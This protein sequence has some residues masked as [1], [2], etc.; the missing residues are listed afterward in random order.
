MGARRSRAEACT[1]EARTSV[2]SS[3]AARSRSDDP[4][5]IPWSLALTVVRQDRSG[6]RLISDVGSGLGGFLGFA[7]TFFPA[8]R[9][10]WVG[11]SETMRESAS[12]NLAEFEPRVRYLPGDFS[13][14]EA[15]APLGQVDLATPARATRHLLLRDLNRVLR[16]VLRAARARWLAREP[17]HHAVDARLGAPTS[18]CR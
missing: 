11:P 3:S 18:R 2:V 7:L 4:A 8:T 15:A 14:I 1:E 13:Q 16:V 17:R 9:G 10:I 6:A 5:A 12:G